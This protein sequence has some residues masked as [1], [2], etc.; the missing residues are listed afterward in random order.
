MSK[1]TFSK[2]RVGR[3]DLE[4]AEL[5]LGTATLPGQLSIE[6]PVA[7]ARGMLD[8][9]VTTGIGYFDT[10]PMYGFGMSEHYVGDALRFR[11]EG[12]VL[13]T[14]VG[15][16]LRPVR[17]DAD[18]TTPSPWTVAFHSITSTTTPTTPSCARSR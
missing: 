14:K 17:T 8:A 6:I 10:A 9:A 12:R 7:Q 15:R 11:Q 13:S 16:L 1:E 4:I 5:G 3:T 18:R 2:R